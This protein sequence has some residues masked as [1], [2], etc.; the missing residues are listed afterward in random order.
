MNSCSSGLLWDQGKN[1][2]CTFQ[3]FKCGVNQ[4]WDGASCR[5]QQGYFYINGICTSCPYGSIFD[6]FQCSRGLQ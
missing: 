5:C 6:G 1:C 2:C 3:N 4:F